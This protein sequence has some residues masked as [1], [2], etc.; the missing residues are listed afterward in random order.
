MEEAPAGSVERAVSLRLPRV[1][2]GG[3]DSQLMRAPC[4]ALGNALPPFLSR[5]PRP[6]VLFL[7]LFSPFAGP[8]ALCAERGLRGLPVP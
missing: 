5:R 8:S 6:N 7:S 1:C 4:S 3:G 2:G